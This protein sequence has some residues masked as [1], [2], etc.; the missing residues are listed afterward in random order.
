MR[1]KTAAVEEKGEEEEED[2]QPLAKKPRSSA[3]AKG[4]AAAKP[5]APT[6]GDEAAPST[7][8]SADVLARIDANKQRA[9]DIKKRKEG[10]AANAVSTLDNFQLGAATSATTSARS[11][12]FFG[13]GSKAS[14]ATANATDTSS[15]APTSNESVQAGRPESD[16]S[17]QSP[18]NDQSSKR[19]AGSSSSEKEPKEESV[20]LGHAMWK[21]PTAKR[22]FIDTA[23]LPRKIQEGFFDALDKLDGFSFSPRA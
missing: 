14:T 11:S 6:D 12:A 9:I 18:S 3:K 13:T 2:D 7:Q 20:P 21:I 5:K 23:V 10:A 4:K 22:S 17:L 19:T 16:L 1:K 15:S 8:L